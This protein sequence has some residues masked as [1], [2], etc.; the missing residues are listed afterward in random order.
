M[1]DLLT[2]YADRIEAALDAALPA[3]DAPY[4]PVVE[5]MRYS[6]LSGGKRVRPALVLE[7]C[8]ICG[9]ATESALPFACAIEMMHTSSL[10]HDDLPCMDDDNYRRGRPSCHIAHGEDVALI[11][12]DALMMDA[13]RLL[14]A[15]DLSADRI[16]AAVRLLSEMSGKDGLVG[17]QMMDL[18]SESEPLSD[19]DQL[20]MYALKTS[21]LLSAACQ[22][23]CIA[24]GRLDR[25]NGAHVFAFNVGLAFQ[26]RDDILDV[27]GDS[28][29][30]GKDT[31]NDNKNGKNTLIARYGIQ[32]A[33]EMVAAYSLAAK[34][35]LAVFG[36]DAA[37]LKELTDF[38]MQR[39]R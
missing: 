13:F 19:E 22:L 26:I 8:R 30:L 16:S 7:F 21:Y 37:D 9:G 15:A 1:A 14:A 31:G 11:A 32:K 25:C 39:D 3:T 20:M 29:V 12:G 10:I 33:E 24:A 27:T 17:G 5:A 36:D 6:L 2:R 34:D 23:R 28:A 18:A 4:A 38:L 35:A